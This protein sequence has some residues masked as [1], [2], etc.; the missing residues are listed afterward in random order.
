MAFNL[1]PAVVTESWVQCTDTVDSG[2]KMT[3]YMFIAMAILSLS[4]SLRLYC[5][6]RD[7]RMVIVLE[8]FDIFFWGG[9]GECGSND[10]HRNLFEPH[11]RKPTKVLSS[12]VLSPQDPPILLTL[13]VY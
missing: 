5:S 10:S 9:G 11:Q 4:S 1:N 12:Q 6:L 8:M 13:F 3:A 2:S 7:C